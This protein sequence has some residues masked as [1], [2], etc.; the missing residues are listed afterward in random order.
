[1]LLDVVNNVVVVI[2]VINNVMKKKT[3]YLKPFVMQN[4]KN[5]H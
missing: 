1:M 3:W 5:Y 2:K 4:V